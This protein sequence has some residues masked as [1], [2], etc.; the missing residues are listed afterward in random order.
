[1]ILGATRAELPAEFLADATKVYAASTQTL[2]WIRAQLPGYPLI[3][4]PQLSRGTHRTTIEFS[5]GIPWRQE[6]FA[7]GLQTAPFSA[8]IPEALG[9]SDPASFA[10]A[11]V[12]LQ[13]RLSETEAW[14][15]YEVSWR[16]LRDDDKR[17]LSKCRSR[18]AKRLS[19]MELDALEAKLALPRVAHRVRVVSE[20][21][22]TLTGAARAFA[23]A[24]ENVDR[25][26]ELACVD[27]LTYLLFYG[28][29][30]LVTSMGSLEYRP[31]PPVATV[32]F[33]A[34]GF[35]QGGE[36]VQLNDPLFSG[37]ALISEVEFKFSAET[38]ERIT[39]TAEMIV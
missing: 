26:I 22:D 35:Y 15:E 5:W 28:Q 25:V 21:I 29:P 3:K 17:Q 12:A 34:D 32:R 16:N 18:I 33:D 30:R 20:E 8:R 9:A 37:L 4:A 13:I 38:G 19:P 36:I 39:A 6:E 2:A 1:M 7:L 27:A 31:G 24:F 11:V 10:L 23:E 14:R